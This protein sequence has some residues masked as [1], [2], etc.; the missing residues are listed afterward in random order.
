MTNESYVKSLPR[1][2]LAA[3]L[4]SQR[5]EPDYDEDIYGEWCE[6]GS[7]TYYVTSD[8]QE[9]CEDYDS[10]LEHQCWWLAQQHCDP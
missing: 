7:S 6:C 9:F 4:I 10:A 8:G 2:Q 1:K 3:M 5:T